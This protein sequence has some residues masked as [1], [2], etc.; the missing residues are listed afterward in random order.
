MAQQSENN[1]A[2]LPLISIPEAELGFFRTALLDW[3]S[4]FGRALPW[5]ETK[6]PYKI[7]LSEV[8]LQQTQ[9]A[10]GWDYYLRFIE[11]YPRV[12]LLAA[13]PEAEV[14][15]MWQG[16]GYYSRALNLHHAAQQIVSE[17]RGVF[18]RTAHEVSKLKG[19]GP[20]TTAAI[21][22]IAFDE[23]LAVVD[24]NVYRVMSRIGAFEVPIDKSFGHKFYQELAHLFL[25]KSNP[26]LYNQAI[27]DLGAMVCTPR[28]P[29]CGEC[30]VAKYCQSAN[31][32][33]LT[34]LLPIK[35]N[36]TKV[37]SLF[38]DFFLL[39]DGEYFYV[40]ERDKRGIWKGLYQLPLAENTEACLT[41]E[42]AQQ[43][44]GEP[45]SFMESITL[46]QHRLTHRLLNIQVHVFQGAFIESPSNY[47]KHPISK[48]AQLA[49]PKPLR[50]FLDSY[51]KL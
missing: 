45:W 13:A 14:L 27:M 43:W 22:S 35:A 17:H 2:Q 11:K 48:H 10:Q 19:I 1:K 50:A 41:Q 34:S 20:Y 16:L 51:L 28:N 30:P 46:P 42:S 44:I 21:M 5:R 9:V 23:P 32:V 18:P 3:F 36:S 29:K 40:E 31:N 47:Q 24:G 26:S 37:V 8:I 39:L 6:D 12:E 38:M 25:D 33:E 4:K 15:L 49:F 7:W